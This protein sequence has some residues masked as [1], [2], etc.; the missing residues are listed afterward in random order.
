MSL[1]PAQIENRLNELSQ[2]IDDAQ[3]KLEE[4]EQVY[5]TTKAAYELSMAKARINLA[6]KSSPTGRNYTVAE[7]ED[8]A[9]A[10]NE[11]EHLA[12]ASAEA[13]VKIARAN[14]A[15]IRTQVDI[16]RSIGTS[17]RTSMDL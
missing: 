10:Q 13:T 2:E 3:A 5:N 6:A 7:R 17:I 9:L 16:A 1:T 12:V 11:L 14:V 15:R 8:L 4:A